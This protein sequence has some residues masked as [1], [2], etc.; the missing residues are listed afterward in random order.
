MRKKK[1]CLALLL[2]M[3]MIASVCIG[4]GSAIAFAEETTE[5][6]A[7]EEA[8]TETEKD[9]EDLD[10]AAIEAVADL[11]EQLPAASEE[12]DMSEEGLN[13]VM[14]Q[15]GIST[16][17]LLPLQEI[18]ANVFLRK[19][20][21]SELKSVSIS[22]ILSN[23][24]SDDGQ[25]INVDLHKKIWVYG[26][27]KGESTLLDEYQEMDVDDKIDISE[28]ANIKGRP[29]EIIIGSDG[30]TNPE[31]IRY[32]ISVYNN[33][34][35]KF[36]FEIYSQ[37]ADNSSRVKIEPERVVLYQGDSNLTDIN[38]NKIQ[39]WNYAYQVK[40][41]DYTSPYLGVTSALDE[42]PD[43]SIEIYEY[44]EFLSD[45]Q[46]AKPITSMLLNPDMDQ[47]GAGYRMKAAGANFIVVYYI[48]GVQTDVIVL[49]I[50]MTG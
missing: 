50:L 36:N 40:E 6:T 21:S 32:I 27:S 29:L 16:M 41:G 35:E 23:L 43:V 9:G 28:F 12:E 5:D 48:N 7:A 4:N 15:G 30:Q 3:I 19:P 20:D 14:Q 25:K 31:N 13:E 45:E 1:R 37:S 38:G 2:A 44:D 34:V 17:S 47:I 42:R 11:F 22:E 10:T 46:N 26:L 33:Y 8:G 49:N 24:I 18:Y 39:A